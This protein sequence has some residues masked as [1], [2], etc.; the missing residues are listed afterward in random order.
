MNRSRRFK[1]GL[2]AV[3]GLVA[4]ALVVGVTFFAVGLRPST[5]ANAAAPAQAAQATP[6]TG[7]SAEQYFA[8]LHQ[9]LANKLGVDE[10]KLDTAFSGAVSD[11]LDQLVKDGQL[12]QQQADSIRAATNKGFTIDAVKAIADSKTNNNATADALNPDLN[13]LLAAVAPVL[14]M[15]QTDLQNQ[16]R[17]GQSLA[18]V[19]QNKHVDAQKV[20][21]AIQS[22]LQTQITQAVSSGK[23]TQQ[24]ATEA[25]QQLSNKVE[26]IF[27]ATNLLGD[28]SNNFANPKFMLIPALDEVAKLLNMSQND[29]LNQLQNGKSMTDIAQAHGVDTQKIQQTILDSGKAQLD[30]AV[31]AGKLTQAQADTAYQSFANFVTAN[32]MSYRNSK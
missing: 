17:V 30:A 26:K 14:N 15:S 28:Q 4:I 12:T 20:K 23:V 7:K 32:F 2:L 10:A 27:N 11:T 18:T 31:S 13:Q 19:A 29:L 25:Q 9:D 1:L 8:A 16:L 22:N 3:M 21:D 5:S 24:Q 6:T